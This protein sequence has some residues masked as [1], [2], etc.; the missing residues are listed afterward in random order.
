MMY[1]FNQLPS[2]LQHITNS[3]KSLT[4]PSLSLISRIFLTS[5]SVALLN[6]GT[7]PYTLAGVTCLPNFVR[8][9]R[10]FGPVLYSPRLYY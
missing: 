10:H 5:L 3:S 8:S 4:Y 9:S 6:P 7:Y 2:K 1:S